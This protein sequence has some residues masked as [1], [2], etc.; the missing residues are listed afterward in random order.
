MK[1]IFRHL[2]R[3]IARVAAAGA[4]ATLLLGT[5]QAQSYINLNVGG[6]LA[7]GVFG[8]IS[9]GNAPPPPVFNPAPVVVMQGAPVRPPA[10]LYVPEEH[11]REWPRYCAQYRACDRPVQFV[12]VNER[13]RWWERHEGYERQEMR[14]EEGRRDWERREDRREDWRNDRRDDRRDDHEDR[15]RHEG[16]RR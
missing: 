3:H 10:Y 13:N 12:E 15:G 6:A 1:P 4:F 14:R 2:P 7:P 16:D 9:I 5:A 11:R 8:E